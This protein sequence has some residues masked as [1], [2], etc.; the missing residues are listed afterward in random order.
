MDSLS[1][2]EVDTLQAQALDVLRSLLKDPNPMVR[3]LAAAEI[4]R[5]VEPTQKTRDGRSGWV[6]KV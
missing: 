4:A 2:R 6:E 1:P 3:L 5:R